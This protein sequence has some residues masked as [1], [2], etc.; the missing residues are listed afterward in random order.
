[1]SKID[2]E[3]EKREVSTIYLVGIAPVLC[4]LS[5]PR[6]RKVLTAG[7]QTARFAEFDIWLQSRR[8]AA[9]LEAALGGPH[10]RSVGGSVDGH[11]VGSCYG[12]VNDD[13]YGGD[14]DVV[15]AGTYGKT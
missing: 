4:A 12:G 6:V 9:F 14:D 1:M 13:G 8:L 10:A 15:T 7:D 11:L 5:A 2:E 3:R